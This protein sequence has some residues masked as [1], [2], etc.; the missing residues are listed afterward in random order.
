[1]RGHTVNPQSRTFQILCRDFGDDRVDSS[2]VRLI[3]LLTNHGDSIVEK[4]DQGA[5]L[6]LRSAKRRSAGGKVKPIV[7]RGDLL[8]LRTRRPSRATGL[9]RRRYGSM[10]G[11]RGRPEAK[12][13]SKSTCK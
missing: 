2:A 11:A 5:S 9:G 13:R 1:V 7:R 3:S 12:S 6:M 10:S 8:I 4:V